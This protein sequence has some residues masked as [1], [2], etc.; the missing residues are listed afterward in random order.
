MRFVFIVLIDV[1]SVLQTQVF[2]GDIA[3]GSS[4]QQSVSLST[5]VP[6]HIV[7]LLLH[8]IQ[9]VRVPNRF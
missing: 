3:E 7:F 4:L 5:M 2:Y 9:R 1:G 6:V 8:A